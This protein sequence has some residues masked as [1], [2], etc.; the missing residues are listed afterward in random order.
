MFHNTTRRKALTIG[1]SSAGMFLGS[2][3]TRQAH[4]RAPGPDKNLVRD[5]TPGSTPIRI[6]E[7]FT[8]CENESVTEAI[9]RIRENGNTSMDLNRSFW[10]PVKDTEVG[11]FK[12]ALKNTVS[13][14]SS[15]VAIRT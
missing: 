5:L 3:A 4:V 10:Q 15:S 7:N 12:E 2:A 1:A 9:K 14:Y 8:R 11:E 13:L 6:S